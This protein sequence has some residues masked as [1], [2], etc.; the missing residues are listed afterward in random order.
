MTS[1]EKHELIGGLLIYILSFTLIF[2]TNAFYQSEIRPLQI[3]H[4]REVLSR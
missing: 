4:A 2:A 1:T 3:N